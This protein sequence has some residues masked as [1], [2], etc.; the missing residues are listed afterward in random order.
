[1]Q[2]AQYRLPLIAAAF[3]QTFCSLATPSSALAARVR[4]KRGAIVGRNTSSHSRIT[5]NDPLPSIW[6][7]SRRQPCRNAVRPRTAI[8]GHSKSRAKGWKSNIEIMVGEA[9][10]AHRGTRRAHRPCLGAATVS[11][12]SGRHHDRLGRRRRRGRCMIF[13]SAPR[14]LQEHFPPG[15]KYQSTGTTEGGSDFESQ[16]ATAHLPLPSDARGRRHS[17][18]QFVLPH[19]APPQLAYPLWLVQRN[20]QPLERRQ[21]LF[22]RLSRRRSMY[23]FS[24]PGSIGHASKSG[25]PYEAS[26]RDRQ[27]AAARRILATTRRTLQ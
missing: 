20:G 27:R 17:D 7:G 23:L 16:P 19:G 24:L 11:G 1:M 3:L 21:L 4:A 14:V 26:V 5:A 8:L 6:R 2:L 22:T 12:Y 10:F 13:K 15:S 9:F 25:S 18:R